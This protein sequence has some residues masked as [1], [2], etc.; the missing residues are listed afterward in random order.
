MEARVEIITPEIARAM[1]GH[2]TH[3]RNVSRPRVLLYAEEMRAGRWR[4]SHQ[5]IA[6]GEDGVLYDGQHRLLAVVESGC[7]VP[8]L[9]IR[10]LPQGS[11]V[12]IDIGRGRNTT[13]NL[14]LSGEQSPICRHFGAAAR[15][16][17][18]VKRSDVHRPSS[19]DFLA[20][21]EEYRATW[22]RIGDA[23]SSHKP[24]ISSAP[25]V[26]ACLCMVHNTKRDSDEE[27]WAFALG[28]GF[29]VGEDDLS[30]RR[31]DTIREARE[32]LIGLRGAGSSHRSVVYERVLRYGHTYVKNARKCTLSREKLFA[33]YPIAEVKP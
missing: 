23:F 22:N 14:N 32:Y 7:S 28:C 6:F 1:L 30:T 12:G 25:A 33:L 20:M 29:Q 5:G 2:N 19:R 9:V 13:D 27:R 26:A 4:E 16:L 31:E 18:D 17:I 21:V 3:N 11:R 24:G 8:M 15:V 10:G